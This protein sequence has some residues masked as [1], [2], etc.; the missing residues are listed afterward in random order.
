MKDVELD[1]LFVLFDG[2]GY[3]IMRITR[4]SCSSPLELV[5]GDD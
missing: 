3:K 5:W 1:E 4:K 2:T